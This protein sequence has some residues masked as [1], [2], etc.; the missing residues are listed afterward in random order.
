M[1]TQPASPAQLTAMPGRIFDK[2]SVLVSQLMPAGIGA[3]VPPLADAGPATPTRE[4]TAAAEIIAAEV[5]SLVRDIVAPGVL[6]GRAVRPALRMRHAGCTPQSDNRPSTWGIPGGFGP[7]RPSCVS[8]N[9]LGWFGLPAAGLIDSNMCSMF[10]RVFDRT[11]LRSVA[12]QNCRRPSVERRSW[13]H[14][15]TP[16]P[17]GLR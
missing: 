11:V 14:R 12:D 5:R 9:D 15:S 2:T 16:S 10:V 3:G 17:G 4:A 7:V 8:L 13:T 6:G 1:P